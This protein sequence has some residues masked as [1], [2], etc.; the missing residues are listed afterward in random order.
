MS[1]AYFGDRAGIVIESLHCPGDATEENPFNLPPDKLA[2]RQIIRVDIGKDPVKEGRGNKGD[3]AT[4]KSEKTGRG[5]LTDGWQASTQPLMTCYKLVT[6]KFE[7]FGFQTKV[8][9][10]A[11]DY[12]QELFTQFHKDIFCAM[13]RWHG[14]TM[15]D[16]RRLEYEIQQELTLKMAMQ[17]GLSEGPSPIESVKSTPF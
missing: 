15:D 4:F 8:E 3:P 5:P 1:H 12:Q 7:Y 2:K 13:D 11:K 6:I 9:A 17:E 10:W 14:L 16:I